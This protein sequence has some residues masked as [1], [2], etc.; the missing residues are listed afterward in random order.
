MDSDEKVEEATPETPSEE[1]AEG[2]PHEG[3]PEG[4]SAE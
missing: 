3:A 2:H 1:S 4:A